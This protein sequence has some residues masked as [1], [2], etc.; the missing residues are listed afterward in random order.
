MSCKRQPLA[1]RSRQRL[2]WLTTFVI[3]SV[4]QDRVRAASGLNNAVADVARVLAIAVLGIVTMDAFASRLNLG[5]AHLAL[6]TTESP[7]LLAV[8]SKQ[9]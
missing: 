2:L 6:P 4:G 7:D 8:A 5:A 3:N 9:V 1:Y